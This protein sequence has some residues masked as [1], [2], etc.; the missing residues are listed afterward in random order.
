MRNAIITILIL[1]CLTGCTTLSD[2]VDA[3]G[4]I[5]LVRSRVVGENRGRVRI[6]Q[7]NVQNHYHGEGKAPSGEAQPAVSITITSGKSR[8]DIEGS[9]GINGTASGKDMTLWQ[10]AKK[11]LA[12]TGGS[13]D[14]D[15]EDGTDDSE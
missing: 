8:Q 2:F 11:R 15:S 10:A 12:G 1:V 5:D 3:N 14:S 6:G 9:G 13:K 7:V 4:S